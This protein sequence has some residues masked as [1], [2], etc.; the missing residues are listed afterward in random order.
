M[1]TAPSV[2]HYAPTEG[3]HSD[4][5]SEP[6]RYDFR[7]GMAAE[8]FAEFV[9]RQ[10]NANVPVTRPPNY[11][12]I[13][14]TIVG[15]LAVLASAKLAWPVA[16]GVVMNKNTWAA[17]SI[18]T[19]LMMTSGHMWNHIRKPPYVVPNQGGVSYIAGGFQNQFGLE[20]QIVAGLYGLCAFCVISL[21]VS[22]PK[23]QEP[24]R[25]RFTI[26]VW[27][28]TLFIIYSLLM[29][30]FRLKNGGYPFKLLF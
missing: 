9:S 22:A 25:Q 10:I 15:G 6:R 3:P 2:F 5:S 29:S 26:M 1:N 27:T 12:K 13:F 14:I 28:G 20:S 30:L 21:I 4:P 23:F 18:V 17:L 11:A 16:R 19:I 7:A 24:Q 8:P